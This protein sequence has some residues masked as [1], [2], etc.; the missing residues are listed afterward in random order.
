MK[1]RTYY[2]TFYQRNNIIKTML[3]ELLQ[4]IAI[5]FRMFIEVFTRKNF[6]ERYF[7]FPLGI[8]LA[9][10][11]AL[12]PYIKA[13][14]GPYSSPDIMDVIIDNITWYIYVAA[15][16]VFCWFRKQEIKR[17]PSVFDF[18]RFSLS[19]GSFQLFMIDLFMKIEISGKPIV[20]DDDNNIYARRYEILLE[21]LIP[22]LLGILLMIL[23]Q[24][25]GTIL[26]ISSLLYSYSY[27]VAYTRGDHF[28]MD[29]IDEMICNEGLVSTFVEGSEETHKGFRPYGRKPVD[30]DKRRQM[31]DSMTEDTDF[32][33]VK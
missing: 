31:F 3:G 24:P 30:E 19:T 2:Q 16:L 1:R 21:P 8:F 13:F 17:L 25:I 6:G 18:E 33:E 4:S 12:M 10:A 5:A 14:K 28:M 29:K 27:A 11:L 20:L 15:F 7:S 9:A 32:E 26:V 23:K 22:F